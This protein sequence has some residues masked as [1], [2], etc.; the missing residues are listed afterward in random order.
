MRRR[1]AVAAA[2]AAW[3]CLF[4]LWKP[5]ATV[6]AQLSEVE[7]EGYASPLEVLLSPDGARLY[8]LCQD[9]AQV[10]VLEAATGQVLQ[11]IPVGRQ[12]R[13]FSFSPDGRRLFVANSWDDT[14]TV[15]DT[16]SGQVKAT[17]AAGFEPSSVAEDRAEKT[18]FV[19]DR[20]GNNVTVLDAATG[21]EKL[22]L[23][24]GRGASYLAMAADGSRLYVT[25]VYPNPTP[26]RTPPKSEITVIDPG[27]AQVVDR[28]LLPNI[29]GVFHVAISRDGKLG[30]AAEL[31]PKNLVPLAHVE[32]GWAFVDTLTVFGADVGRSVEVPLD[33]LDRYYAYSFGV[34]IAPDKSRIY[35]THGGSDCVTVIDTKKMLAYIREHP[36]PF[37]EDLSA[38]ANY[39]VGRIAVGKN[40]RGAALS[41]DGAKLY[42]A[43]RLDDTISVID[44]R[45]NRVTQTIKLAGP[46]KVSALRRGEQTFYKAYSFQGQ[47]GCSNCH[48]D[49]T[50]DGLQWDLEPDGFGRDIVDNRLIEDLRGT[51]PFKWNGGNPTLVKECGIRTEMYFWRSQNY[52]DRTLTDLV[53]YIRSL[54][55]RPNRWRAAN[56]VLTPAQERGRAVFY[57]TI[58]KLGQPIPQSNQCGYCHSGPKGTSQKSFDVGTGKPTDNSGL[59]DTPQLMS[60]ALTAPYLHDGSAKSLEEIWT[61]YNP[62]DR[63][64]RTNDLTKDEL[65]DLVE[66][67]RTR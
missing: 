12:P 19:A 25:H 61:V 36:E 39:V 67:L 38:S 37:A 23:E 27:R 26:H 13:G 3:M 52:D 51:E 53:L 20:I 32:H 45:A 11:T 50:F 22:T 59:L 28:L 31:H 17:W 8:V 55:S 7:Q 33:E 15:I 54:P 60:L 24:A 30:V 21:A 47:F 46:E 40:P 62:H 18:L 43:N 14:V 2:C 35:V 6:N 57:R 56:G 58:D 64:G 65:N 1:F 66:Y 42:V 34:A 63:H 41:R 44:T 9:T 29:A 16:Q 5:A 4:A 10:R 49:S 48:I